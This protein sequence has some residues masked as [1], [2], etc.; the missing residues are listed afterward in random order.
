MAKAFLTPHVSM[1]PISAK[2]IKTCQEENTI[3]QCMEKL[4]LHG[5]N[6]LKRM[7][8]Q[9]KTKTKTQSCCGYLAAT[10]R[11]GQLPTEE[12]GKTPMNASLCKLNLRLSLESLA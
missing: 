6:I 12:Q 2:N 8:Q 4:E 1:Y 3:T 11:G 5:S 9:R 10:K 7:Q